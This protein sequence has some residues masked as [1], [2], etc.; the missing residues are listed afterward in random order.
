MCALHHEKSF[1]PAFKVSIDN[2][3]VNPD[4]GKKFTFL[5]KGLEKVLILDPKI[6]TNPVVHFL[7][8]FFDLG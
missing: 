2:L 7:W 6:R 3:F 4:C 1:V 5:E 8:S